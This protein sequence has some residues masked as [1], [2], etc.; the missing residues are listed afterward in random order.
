M[1]FVLDGSWGATEFFPHDNDTAR[2]GKLGPGAWGGHEHFYGDKG[3]DQSVLSTGSFWFTC[4]KQD[5]DAYKIMRQPTDGGSDKGEKWQGIALMPDDGTLEVV[6]GGN[7]SQ[8]VGYYEIVGKT[9]EGRICDQ[10][11]GNSY[12]QTARVPDGVVAKN[13]QLFH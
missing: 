12:K 10:G 3:K 6:T 7:D 11:N 8:G 5:G 4:E 13:P 9:L 2:L 1:F